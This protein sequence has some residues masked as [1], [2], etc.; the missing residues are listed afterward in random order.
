MK[1]RELSIKNCLS[2]CDKGLN[3]D[4]RIDL[5][6][7]NLFIGS[8]N[9]GKSNALKMVKIINAI[10]FSLRQNGN[11]LLS[12]IPLS[13]VEAGINTLFKDWA[14]AHD[15]TRKIHFSFSLEIEESDKYILDTY[16]NT[17]EPI[18]SNFKLKQSWPK[19][20][21]LT[22]LIE[23]KG[24]VPYI[25]IIK[26]DIPNDSREPV[27]FDAERKI[28]L[29]LTTEQPGGRHV[30]KIKHH[31]DASNWDNNCQRVGGATIYFMSRLYD[32]IMQNL[33]VNI[34]AI[35][36]IRPDE[37]IISALVSLRDG[38]LREEEMRRSI[39]SFLK[40]LIFADQEIE[41]A[42]P[43][44]KTTGK[45][46]IE[47]RTKTLQLP[48]SHYGS[49][50]EQMLFLATEIVRKGP[51]KVILIEEPE[52]HFHPELQRK[53][54]KF[55]RDNQDVFKHQYLIATHS[56]I[57]IDEFFSMGQ[58]VFYVYIGEDKTIKTNYTQVELLNR[59]HQ[60]LPALL[61]DLGAKPSD[62][63][64]ANGVLVVEGRTDKDVYMDWAR[65]I[66]KPFEEVTLEVIDVDGAGN[67]SKYLSS[68]VIQR[69]CF[70][71][72]ALCDKNAESDIRKKLEEIVPEDNIIALK[73]GDLEDYYP[74]ELVIK[75]AGEWAKRKK[76]S[77]DKVPSTIADG[78]TVETINKLLG[79]DWWK[80]KLA[81]EIIKEMKAE[82]IDKEIN[83]DISR[84]HDS[85]D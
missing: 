20:L 37:D 12:N 47:I 49:G 16:D 26:V 66:G 73:K 34:F 74:R 71:R 83:E 1:I 25:T 84:I 55:L 19:C 48:L 13:F 21:S 46:L 50:V 22:G 9:A 59:E 77:A 42:F 27:V 69:S 5:G 29:V 54:I 32:K 10:L 33:C 68:A 72:Y 85:I 2:F 44:D 41:F 75:F 81:E 70:G 35:R 60:K 79:E 7:F 38:R 52:A 78:K 4:N 62:I 56:N 36:E 67:I 64:M 8:N 43:P 18:I 40:Q 61:R 3:A 6:D 28:C 58:N 23:F 82:Q 14:Y 17:E 80:T 63:L 31:P 15:L 65:K 57:F 24:E 45:R 53:F 30:W 39:Q 76:I 11:N 51:N